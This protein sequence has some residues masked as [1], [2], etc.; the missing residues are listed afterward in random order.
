MHAQSDSVVE[1]RDLLKRYPDVIAVDGLSLDIR[2][3]EIFGMV[4]PN[5]AGKTT[6]IECIEGLRRPD[7]GTV[8]VLGLDPQR[9]GYELRERIGIQFQSAALPPRIRV[10]EAL[11]LFAS[12]YRSSVDWRPLLEQMGLAD[13][14]RFTWTLHDRVAG[15]ACS[16]APGLDL[17]HAALPAADQ[18][19]HGPASGWSRHGAPQPTQTPACTNQEPAHHLS[20]R[21]KRRHGQQILWRRWAAWPGVRKRIRQNHL[22]QGTATRSTTRKGSA[23]PGAHRL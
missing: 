14:I 23:F 8:R 20:I 4:G 11:D 12:F 17:S 1:V 19:E 16:P 10:G 22:Q 18:H 6:T 2:A 13:P 9:D 5:G 7:G 21:V 3:G 15:A